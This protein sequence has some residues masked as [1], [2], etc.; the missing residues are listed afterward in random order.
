M[1]TLL[2]A[3]AFASSTCP[4]W[5]SPAS[6]GTLDPALVELSG[7]SGSRQDDTILWAHNDAGNQAI[8]YAI[9][10]AG[11]LIKAVSVADATNED[12]EDISGG[13]CPDSDCPCLYIGDIGDN[14]ASRL[15]GV[16]YRLPEPDLMMD[17][18]QPTATALPFQ[19]PDG[20]RD[21]EALVVHPQTGAVYIITKDDPAHIYQMP[22]DATPAQINTV[23]FVQ[24]LDVS[25]LT[26]AAITAA[27]FSPSGGRLVLRTDDEIILLGDEQSTQPSEVF[28]SDVQQ[29]LPTPDANQA[30]S[31]A[32]DLTGA[33][34]YTASEGVAVDFWQISCAE[35]S[36]EPATLQAPC[37]DGAGGCG[38]KRAVL[39]L[40]LFVLGGM[41]RRVSAHRYIVD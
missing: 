36:T 35:D 26:N 3:T 23:T 10:T 7:L 31:I 37:P 25:A 28:N 14:D 8:V 41:R 40:P 20:P 5:S 17:D 15:G 30:E 2:I 33:H 19:Y 38:G 22:T 9:S 27:D 39:L 21:A 32:F 1:H 12:W 34:L 24:E 16:I 13:P 18:P 6:S 29:L 4:Q 11:Q